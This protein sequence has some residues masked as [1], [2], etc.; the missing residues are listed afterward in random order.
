M[1]RLVAPPGGS[2]GSTSMSF[3]FR[4]GTERR[5]GP[6]GPGGAWK[7]ARRQRELAPRS[8]AGTFLGVGLGIVLGACVVLFAIRWL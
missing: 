3:S 5:N 1:E 6:R 4:L 8:L 2:S 7:A